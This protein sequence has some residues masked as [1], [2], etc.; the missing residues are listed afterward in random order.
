MARWRFTV[1]SAVGFFIIGV[2]FFNRKSLTVFLCAER[3]ERVADVS[4]AIEGDGV[5]VADTVGVDAVDA[6]AVGAEDDSGDTEVDGSRS[7]SGEVGAVDPD[8]ECA[9]AEVDELG[10]DDGIGE[11]SADGKAS[12]VAVRGRSKIS[13]DS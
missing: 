7:R 8:V 3:G 13:A 2:S 11:A 6:D 12:S 4:R 1:G 5:V 9:G 10:P